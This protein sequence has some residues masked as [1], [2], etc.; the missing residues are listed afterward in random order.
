MELNTFSITAR[1]PGIGAVSTQSWV[2]PYLAFDTVKLMAE[3]VDA[4][5]ALDRVVQAD[6]ARNVRQVGGVDAHG[7]SASFSGADCTS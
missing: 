4:A 2:N 1:C 7:G 3:G 6:P 5:T